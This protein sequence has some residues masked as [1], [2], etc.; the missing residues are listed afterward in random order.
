MRFGELCKQ[1]PFMRKEKARQTKT[2]PPRAGTAPFLWFVTRSDTFWHVGWHPLRMAIPAVSIATGQLLNAAHT[3]SQKARLVFCR[4]PKIGIEKHLFAFRNDVQDDLWGR[5]RDGAEN[6]FRMR[7]EKGG[8]LARPAEQ[9]LVVWIYTTSILLL[10][11]V[12]V[13]VFMWIKIAFKQRY[14]NESAGE[15]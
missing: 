7:I 8:F 10:A 4:A 15:L 2:K 9:R 5:H 11:K 3:H 14:Q 12:V 13:V 6:H 1:Q